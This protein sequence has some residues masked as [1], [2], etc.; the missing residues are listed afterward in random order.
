[1]RILLERHHRSSSEEQSRQ[2]SKQATP[3]HPALS[4]L[5][6]SALEI[7]QRNFDL[8]VIKY[9]HAL[10]LASALNIS[11]CAINGRFINHQLSR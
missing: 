3:A 4:R 11:R 8:F 1:M 9:W 2:T 10:P 6:E 7:P 5:N